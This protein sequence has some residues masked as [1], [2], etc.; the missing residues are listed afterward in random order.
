MW[1]CE[2]WK[3]KVSEKE[4]HWND[5]VIQ[6][7]TCV[8]N[9]GGP[10]VVVVVAWWV[11]GWICWERKKPGS[12]GDPMG[13]THEMLNHWGT[14]IDSA[15]S[16]AGDISAHGWLCY[17]IY[18]EPNF[19]QTPF[20]ISRHSRSSSITISMTRLGP[21]GLATCRR[22]DMWEYMQMRTMDKHWN[23][24]HRVNIR[25]NFLTISLHWRLIQ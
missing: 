17:N 20:V 21:C 13:T 25:A 16:V 19:P 18:S 2:I 3:W 8:L 14:S 9:G 7:V 11:T 12:V 10:V 22:G 5:D 24:C 15:C 6:S 23:R 4:T 1:D